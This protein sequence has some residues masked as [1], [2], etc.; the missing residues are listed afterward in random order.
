[1]AESWS[2]R[3]GPVFL[4][5]P[6]DV[7]AVQVPDTWAEP[8]ALPPR[9]AAPDPE[10]QVVAELAARI[11]AA[12]RPVLLL[13]GGLSHRQARAL[14]PQL[15]ALNLP[16]MTTWNGADR[17]PVDH[18]NYAG[19]PNTWGQRSSNLIL[20]QADLVLAVGSRL[21]LQQT[22]FNWRQFV[23]LGQV[24]Q[25]DIDPAELAKPNPNLPP[26]SRP[27]PIASWRRCWSTPSAIIV[28]GW[29][30]ARRCVR[31]CRSPN[32]AISPRKASSIPLTWWKFSPGSLKPVI[33]S[34]LAAAMAPSP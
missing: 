14:E 13:G 26:A 31:F 2:G 24:I 21:Y 6:L 10:P 11:G 33:T 23:P 4:E 34:C 18:A 32:P 7:Q 1:M 16:I 9:A 15:A 5:L 29:P 25:V 30:S 22:G 8:M 17:Y 27:M 3:P 19:R 12:S 28:T 20:Q